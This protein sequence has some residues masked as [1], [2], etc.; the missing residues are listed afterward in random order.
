MAA[1]AIAPHTDRAVELECWDT[2]FAELFK[3]LY[4]LR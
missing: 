1:G 3:F 2:T 4:T